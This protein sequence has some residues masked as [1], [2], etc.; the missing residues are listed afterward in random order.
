MVIQVLDMNPDEGR[1]IPT[2]RFIIALVDVVCVMGW[3]VFGEDSQEGCGTS[4]W[5]L[6]GLG[7]CDHETFVLSI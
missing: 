3:L 7:R 5:E 6:N 2:Q 4:G 1:A